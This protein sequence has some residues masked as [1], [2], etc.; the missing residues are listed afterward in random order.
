MDQEIMFLDLSELQ[1][2]IN[3][4]PKTQNLG[5]AQAASLEVHLML[6][7]NT[8]LILASPPS[9]PQHTISSLLE[10]RVLKKECVSIKCSNVKILSYVNLYNY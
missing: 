10:G 7:V 1:I 2:P 4:K 5:S 6:S 8:N 3:G 9:I